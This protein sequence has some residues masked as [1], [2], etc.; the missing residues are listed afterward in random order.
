M[1]FSK[2]S[3]LAFALSLGIGMSSCSSAQEK[4]KES[5]NQTAEVQEVAATEVKLEKTTPEEA[6]EF[7]FMYKVSPEN[8]ELYEEARKESFAI[9]ATEPGVLTYDI[10]K[11][12]EGVYAQRERYANEAALAAHMKNTEKSLAKWFQ[13]T[14]IQRVLTF[15]KI[16]EEMKKQLQLQEIFTFDANV[17]KD[18]NA[19]VKQDE[20]VDYFFAFNVKP[21]NLARYEEVRKEQFRITKTEPTTL[22]YDVFKDENGMYWQHER[23]ANLAAAKLHTTNT[24]Q[25]LQ[26]WFQLVELK[27][28]IELTDA[29]QMDKEYQMDRYQ[30]YARVEK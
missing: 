21:E 27:Q 12:E 1:S 15:G 28:I 13:A 19:K 22:I 14:E 17:Q 10:Y 5:A 7:V 9:T 16:S 11:S 4:T 25:Y 23:Y 8:Q 6:L 30:P 24:A 2:I 26:E 18:H 3:T 20:V 29:S